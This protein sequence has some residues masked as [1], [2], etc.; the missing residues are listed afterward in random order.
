MSTEK[1]IK[2][3]CPRC[4]KVIVQKVIRKT[5]HMVRRTVHK[6][7]LHDHFGTGRELYKQCKRFHWIKVKR[8]PTLW[9]SCHLCE[10]MEKKRKR[11][12]KEKQKEKEQL[13][14]QQKSILK[15]P[16]PRGSIPQPGFMLKSQHF[17]NSF[18]PKHR[19]HGCYIFPASMN[20]DFS[21]DEEEDYKH[22]RSLTPDYFIP[23]QQE[24]DDRPKTPTPFERKHRRVRFFRDE[25]E[26][27]DSDS[28]LCN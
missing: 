16:M 26:S 17:Y 23:M 11:K 25:P 22:K 14:Q 6:P 8:L 13:Q 1:S 5:N 3:K 19:D 7:Y 9:K 10:E 4:K 24:V 12:Q 20:S 18:I 28:I 15:K 27:S 21:D 2:E